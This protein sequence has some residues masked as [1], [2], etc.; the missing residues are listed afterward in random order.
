MPLPLHEKPMV[1]GW[2]TLRI[3]DVWVLSESRA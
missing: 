3:T 2:K 1:N